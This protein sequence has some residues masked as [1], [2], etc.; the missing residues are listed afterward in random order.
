MCPRASGKSNRAEL[1]LPVCSSTGKMSRFITQFREGNGIDIACAYGKT[2]YIIRGRYSAAAADKMRAG[3]YGGR[4]T[5]NAI[6]P[7]SINWRRNKLTRRNRG[8]VLGRVSRCDIA[9]H[10]GAA[11]PREP[12]GGGG[13]GGK[14]REAKKRDGTIR[15]DRKMS[16]KRDART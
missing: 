8:C 11:W 10:Q 4:V 6:I 2:Y 14:G 7:C 15:G 1:C 13:E 9:M 16:E 12:E 5:C 3:G